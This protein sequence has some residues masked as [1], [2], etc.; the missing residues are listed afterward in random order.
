MTSDL[1]SVSSGWAHVNSAMPGHLS[2]PHLQIPQISTFPHCSSYLFCTTTWTA[3]AAS[4]CVSVMADD[5]SQDESSSNQNQSG[6]QHVSYR[7]ARASRACEVC[8]SRKV[9]CDV[10]NRMPCTNCVAFGC[11]CK[12]PDARRRKMSD[13]RSKRKTSEL[14]AALQTSPIR[15]DSKND[16]DSLPNSNAHGDHNDFCEEDDSQSGEDGD[17]E[18][19][20]EAQSHDSRPR[21]NRK[22]D[23]SSEPEQNKS[24]EIGLKTGSPAAATSGGLAAATSGMPNP[25]MTDQAEAFV[26]MLSNTAVGNNNPVRRS[27][28]VAYLGSSSNVS[29]LVQSKAGDTEVC[30]YPLPDELRVGSARLNELD[31]EEIEMLNRRGA[32]LLPPRDICD[33][34]VECFFTTIH[35]IVPM[36]N[37]TQFMRRYNDPQNPPSLLLLQSILLAGTR[38][39]RNPALMD[40]NGSA[41][42]ASLTLYKRAKALYDAN[43]EDDRISIVQSLVLLGW[44]WEGPEDVTKNVFYWT[45]VALSVAQGFGI[46]RSVEHSQLSIVDKRL[47]KRLWWVLFSRDRNVAIALGRPVL[48]NT[49]DTDVPMLVEGDFIEEAG[50]GPYEYPPNRLHVQ[51]F[52]QSLKLS[53]IMGLVLRQ[54]FSVASENSR[55]TNRGPDITHSDMALGSWMNNLPAELRYNFRDRSKHNFFIALLHL[56]YYTILCLLHRTNMSQGKLQA[57]QVGSSYLTSYPSRGIAFQAAHMIAKIIE[58]MA[59][60]DELRNVAAFTVYTL[61]SA[62]IMFVYQT[63]SQS[64]QVV[65]SAQRAMKVCMDALQEVGKSWMVGRMIL[66]LFEKINENKQMKDRIFRAV[67]PR[68]HHGH[69]SGPSTSGMQAASEP[70][71]LAGSQPSCPL[72]SKSSP[73][74][75]PSAGKRQSIDIPLATTPTALTASSPSVVPPAT[76][77]QTPSLPSTPGISPTKA[78]QQS[79]PSPLRRPGPSPVQSSAPVM[80]SMAAPPPPSRTESNTGSY[81]LPHAQRPTAPPTPSSF[82]ASFS[83][84]GTPPDFYFVTHSPPISQSFFENFQPSQLFPEDHVN[85]LKSQEQPQQNAQQG[86]PPGQF[87]T[88][89]SA[90]DKWPSAAVPVSVPATDVVAPVWQSQITNGLPDFL[91]DLDFDQSTPEDSNASSSGSAAGGNKISAGDSQESGGPF[92]NI[93][94]AYSGSAPNSLN[95][96]D[97]YNFLVTNGASEGFSDDMAG[98]AQSSGLS[99]PS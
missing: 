52:I 88:K 6:K 18:D 33:E 89:S 62:M 13:K 96:G 81:F 65:E 80:H 71:L 17:D 83:V 11:E 1:T 97:W 75:S 64:P 36:I 12:I 95:I 59:A 74:L 24:S 77:E 82:Q 14:D 60:A 43:Y 87:P 27:G 19:D 22:M 85:T 90:Q 61:F 78:P 25:P 35:P 38:V 42:M 50:P 54:Q 63:K 49:E 16:N 86:F 5:S 45:R 79:Q 32:F 23:A 58:N 76:Y 55:M 68:P 41:D 3:T 92:G 93:Q 37:R 28:R 4:R 2:G 15:A 39:C 31:P 51:Y 57:G 30:H 84:P 21:K 20:D 70:P 8:H 47:W 46:H 66:R 94:V 44:W 7:R 34:L 72:P 98:L 91:A 73:S 26:R 53:E 29:L 40:Q 99:L 10:T 69:H 9:R 56:Q 48:I 67:H